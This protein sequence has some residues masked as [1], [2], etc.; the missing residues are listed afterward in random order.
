KGLPDINSYSKGDILV[1]INVWTP[2]NLNKEEKAIL[3][4]LRTAENF[5]PKPS[6]KDKSFF[7]RMREYFQ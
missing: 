1:N 2:Q 3:E 4:K 5:H 7:E 6:S